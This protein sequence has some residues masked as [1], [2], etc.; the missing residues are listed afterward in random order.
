[1]STHKT[2]LQTIPYVE[3]IALMALMTSMIALSIDA[4]LPA[5]PMIGQDLGVVDV[6]DNQL[7]ISLLFLGLAI[8]QMLYGP[9]S[10]SLGRKPTL[11]IGLAIYVVG[12]VMSIVANNLE[13]MLV[14]RFLQGFGVASPRIVSMAIVRDQYEGKAMAQVMSFVM[15]VFIL[16]PMVAPALGQGILWIADWRTIFGLFLGLAFVVWGWFMAR[17][18]ETLPSDRRIPFKLGK[19]GWAMKEVIT[20]RIAAGYIVATGF[21]FSAFL[22]YLSSAQQIFQDQYGLGEQFPLYFAVLAFSIGGASFVNGKMVNRFGMQAMTQASLWVM[23]VAAILFMGVAYLTSGNPV[24]WGLMIYLLI[25]LFCVGV[26]MGNLNALAM[27]PLGHVAG[28]GAAM[29][30][31][32]STLISVPFGV[33]IGQSFDGTIFPLVFGFAGFTALS[34]IVMK[35][36][37][38]GRQSERH[39]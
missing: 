33:W 4:M 39:E 7:V 18:P 30:G 34:L 27:E 9:L 25:T 12:C 28:M 37:E 14:G 24:L 8:G 17:Q 31:S 10:D 20:Q 22:G 19:I 15:M 1:M 5:L 23:L 29:V 21:V 11:Y 3:F 16:V 6:N 2:A 36:T 13:V 32:L 38:R 26:L 35:W